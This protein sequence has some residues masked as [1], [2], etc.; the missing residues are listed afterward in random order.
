MWFRESAE[1]GRQNGRWYMVDGGWVYETTTAHRNFYNRKWLLAGPRNLPVSCSCFC[2]SCCCWQKFCFICSYAASKLH[3]NTQKLYGYPVATWWVAANLEAL[4]LNAIS[5]NL[6]I[7]D[8]ID[9]NFNIGTPL[10]TAWRVTT[11][12]LRQ[13]ENSLAKVFAFQHKTIESNWKT[14]ITQ[15]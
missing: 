4:Y 7:D 12:A 14:L 8:A 6:N 13:F 5:G 15:A 1:G 3:D 10:L 9:I 2:L 11:I